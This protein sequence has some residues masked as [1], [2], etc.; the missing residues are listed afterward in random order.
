LSGTIDTVRDVRA[1][2]VAHMRRHTLRHCW[3]TDAFVGDMDPLTVLRLV[4]ASL[5]MN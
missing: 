2:Y 1:D 5:E 4:G 3:I